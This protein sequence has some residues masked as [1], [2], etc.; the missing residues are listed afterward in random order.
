MVIYN[1]ILTCFV[2]V[3]LQSEG[4]CCG[5]I[6]GMIISVFEGYYMY[7]A[8]I[9]LTAISCYHQV[10]MDFITCDSNRIH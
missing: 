10:V 3:D 7:I 1:T 9:L 4:R 6:T 5:P 2:P 8:V